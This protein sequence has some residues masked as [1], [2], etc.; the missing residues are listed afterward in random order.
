VGRISPIIQNI[1]FKGCISE[2]CTSPIQVVA[3]D[4]C[5]GT[6]TYTYEPLDGGTIIGSGSSVV[7]APPAI[8]PGYPCPYRIK[9]A[10]AS[11]GSGLL[12]SRTIGIYVKIPGDINGDGL[13]NP[14]D[15][16]LLRKK[17]GW[18]G[19][20]GSTPE[21]MN[22]DGLVNPTE[23]LLLREKLGLDWGC[24]CK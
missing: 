14:T 12:T 24:G 20:P 22:C 7:F 3:S 6:L 8:S 11:S 23:L 21:D 9:V 17:L 13:V 16:L 19:S 18:S 15:L 5:G 1:S 10:V 4:P 2:L